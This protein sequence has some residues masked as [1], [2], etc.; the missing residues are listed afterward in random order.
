MLEVTI[1]EAQ[2]RLSELIDKVVNGEIVIITK[3][4]K[5]IAKMI[6]YDDSSDN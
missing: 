3:H 5:P 1:R 6:P 4:G 2:K